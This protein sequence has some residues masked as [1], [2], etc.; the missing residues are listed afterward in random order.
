[1]QSLASLW[2]WV[3]ANPAFLLMAWPILTAG[4]TTIFGAAEGYAEKHPRFHAVLAFC[5]AAGLDPRGVIAALAKLLNV[6]AQAAKKA[7]DK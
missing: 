7:D 2:A 6:P 3:Q 5:E 4:V 1:M